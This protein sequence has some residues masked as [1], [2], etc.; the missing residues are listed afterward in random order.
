[1]RVVG[2]D[3]KPRIGIDLGAKYEPALTKLGLPRVLEYDA[4]RD[5]SQFVVRDPEFARFVK[6]LAA[7]IVQGFLA[8]SPLPGAWAQPAEVTVP[9][10]TLLVTPAPARLEGTARLQFTYL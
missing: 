1:M 7:S 10:A 6:V 2:E 8:A 9:T 3:A 5:K 4:S